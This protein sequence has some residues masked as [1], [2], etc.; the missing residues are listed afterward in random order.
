MQRDVLF[1]LLNRSPGAVFVV[2]PN[3]RL[4]RA[5]SAEFDGNQA[6]QGLTVWQTPQVLPFAAFVAKL[7]DMAQHTPDLADVRAPLTRVQERAVWEGVIADSGL[8]LLP[9]AVAAAL[10]ANAWMLAHQWNVA[11]RV[12][13]Y[14]AVADT[15]VFTTW[16]D[17]YQRRV[18]AMAATDAARLPDVMR[19]FI[20]SGAVAAPEHV[21][22][23]GF[24][25][26]TAQQQRFF[27]A[28]QA[29]GTVCE[30][31][32]PSRH[33]AT[34]L[35][36]S[37]LDVRDENKRMADWATARIAAD[38]GVRVG[39]VV[40]DLTTR[41]RSLVAALDAALMS[42]R[43]V[44]PASV[45]PYTVS[46]GGSLSDV[47][48]VAFYLRLL[49]LPLV[50]VE[51]EEA[52]VVL[53]SPYFTGAADERAARDVLDAQ[54]RRRCRS[55]LN[56]DQLFEAAQASA[57]ET[58][59]NVGQLLAG[60][61]TLN[62]W[63]RQ[64][65]NRSRMPSEWA[66]AFAQL[67]GSIN[68]PSGAD[69]ALD[70]AEYQAR[71]R[72]QES[73][74]EFAALD[75]AIRRISA[76]DAMRHLENIAGEAVFQPEGGTPPVQVLGVLEANGLTFDHLWV[77]GLT[78]DAWPPPARP[79][80]L[81]PVELQRAVGM[82]GASAATELQ[83]ARRQL[84]QLLQS[85]PEV[86]VSHATVEADRK[87]APSPLIAT[88]AQY[89]PPKRAA[90]LIDAIASVR[91]TATLDA[92]APPL[93]RKSPLEPMGAAPPIPLRGGASV[94]QNQ[95]ACPF[96]A[97][98]TH[99][100]N[101]RAIESP[102]DGFDYRE[103]GQLVH[104]TL[105]AFWVALPE[106]TRDA[107]ATMPQQDRRELLRIAAHAAQLRL[108]NRRGVVST[109]LTELESD[110]LVRVIDQW[111]RYELTARTA[112][113][114]VAIEEARAMH[115]GPLTLAARLDRVDEYPDGSRV[116][117]DY[118]TG[119]AK[120]AGWLDARPDEP[121]L[122]LYLTAAEPAARAIALARVRA[123]DVGLVGLSADPQLLPG[124]SSSWNPPHATWEALVD[125]WS[126]VLER[127]AIQFADG[128]A[129]VDPKRLPQTCRFCDLPT[130]CRI[131][132]R[133]GSVVAN[134]LDDEES[135]PWISDEE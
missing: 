6:S 97:F 112:F 85:A 50:T 59:V 20:D 65:A 66:G 64:Y 98:A 61:R 81:L 39:V 94:L 43:L 102:H 133:G 114:V 117:I 83:R 73:L 48:L 10:A 123:G 44:K 49:R 26:T 110:R 121:Q 14:T 55:S 31:L 82:P 37:C 79:D 60:L 111:L 42:D 4:S 96:R 108:Q 116:V 72:W 135:M 27:D 23:A 30:R 118:K 46:L 134:L 92:I 115:V 16:T 78:A 89:A 53:R 1:E 21:V 93:M 28:L 113:R 51:F 131:N 122:L 9:S 58:G 18:T 77:M 74:G 86:I 88:F 32:E 33:D 101:A 76:A 87:L 103:R 127:L 106:P 126:S 129:A 130:L 107:L 38:P 40:P 41:R 120:N 15:R 25:D 95:A 2:T 84:Q 19:A 29:R 34:P 17:E 70:S 99:R 47:A 71:A 13:Q 100:L 3:R 104:D 124:R 125:H 52:S 62:Q 22:L 68:L 132:E 63:R 36:A 35:R 67:L 105:A 75:R 5:I 57:R 7:H 56:F 90:R 91:L 11:T 119:G 45:R 54:L 12:R 24:E 128:V 80:A 69:R 8:G 109:A